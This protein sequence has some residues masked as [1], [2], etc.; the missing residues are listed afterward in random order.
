MDWSGV[1]VEAGSANDGDATKAK[2]YGEDRKAAMA[3]RQL[4][5]AERDA[6]QTYQALGQAVDTF[7]TAPSPDDG[8]ISGALKGTV[9]TAVRAL[10]PDSVENARSHINTARAQLQVLGDKSLKGPLTDKDMALLRLKG[11]DTYKLPEENRRVIREAQRDSE[12]RQLRALMTDRWI[13]RFG[14][15]TQASPNGT[16][17]EDAMQGAEKDLIRNHWT[18]K[19]PARRSLPTPP[20]SVRSKPATNGWGIRKVR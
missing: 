3:A 4:A 1:K 10:I 18:P 11:V 7:D 20:P 8:W 17:F 19:P 16:S 12:V 2:T 14:S 6:Q 13:S 5:A 15:L 9:G